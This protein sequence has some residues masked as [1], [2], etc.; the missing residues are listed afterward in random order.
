LLFKPGLIPKLEQGVLKALSNQLQKLSKD[1]R[2][3]F[4]QNKDAF[5]IVLI[6][7]KKILPWKVLYYQFLK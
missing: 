3:T 7:I 2:L 4:M 5:L 1:G 6:A